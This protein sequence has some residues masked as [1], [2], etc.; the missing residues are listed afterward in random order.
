MTTYMKVEQVRV[1][2]SHKV[3]PTVPDLQTKGG[4]E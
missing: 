2:I 3:V 1:T 4:F